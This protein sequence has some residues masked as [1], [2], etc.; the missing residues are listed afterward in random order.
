MNVIN[1]LISMYPKILEKRS[2]KLYFK[3][4]DVYSKP[5][6]IKG[7]GNKLG[8]VIAIYP[9]SGHTSTTTIFTALNIIND[10]CLGK[11]NKG[12]L[13]FTKYVTL[14]DQ[15][16]MDFFESNITIGYD[17]YEYDENRNSFRIN[18]KYY[19]EVEIKRRVTLNNIID[20]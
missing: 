3:D 19:N 17:E 4:K 6:Y 5:L 18:F 16:C 9:N 8:K 20:G 10:L 2:G 12:S 15:T 1:E 7:D 11:E 13:Y 14:S